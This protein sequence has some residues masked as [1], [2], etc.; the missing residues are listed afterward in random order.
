MSKKSD[1]ASAAEREFAD[2]LQE[3]KI[4]A[5]RILKSRFEKA[6][7]VEIE[8]YKYIDLDE[9]QERIILDSKYSLSGFTT[10]RLQSQVEMKYCRLPTDFS[11]CF[12]RSYKSAVNRGDKN[13]MG[14]DAR[15]GSMLLA[16]WLGY[17]TK[18]ELWEIFTSKNKFPK[19]EV[20]VEI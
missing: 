19:K 2:H 3:F 13:R 5:K 20:K 15:L 1:H 18:E 9:V 16:Y 10:D 17:G 6:P 14:M 8:G 7:D 4:P 12:F 11:I